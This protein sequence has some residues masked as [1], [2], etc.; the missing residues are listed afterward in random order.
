MRR[1]N[2]IEPRDSWKT[3]LGLRRGMNPLTD[4]EIGTDPALLATDQFADQ[5]SIAE[6]QKNF[7]G[8]WTNLKEK[9]TLNRHIEDESPPTSHLFT[10][11]ICPHSY[12]RGNG[13]IGPTNRSDRSTDREHWSFHRERGRTGPERNNANRRA[14][15]KRPRP[16]WSAGQTANTKDN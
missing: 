2:L 6:V 8:K 14:K 16:R 11:P 5:R 10:P 9:C 15:K 4:D 7:W 12:W 13:L 1:A 3:Q